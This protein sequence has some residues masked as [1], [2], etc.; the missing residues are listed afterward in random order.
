MSLT[1][2]IADKSSYVHAFFERNFP[3][4]IATRPDSISLMS[5]SI[6]CGESDTSSTTETAIN[7]NFQFGEPL[8]MPENT[9]NYPWAIVGTAF[10][11]RLRYFLEV[12]P[13]EALVA[14]SGAYQ[15]RMH[16]QSDDLPLAFLEL[17]SEFERL[18]PDFGAGLLAPELE[19]YVGSLCIAL[20]QYEACYRAQIR[21]NW[22]VIEIGEKGSLKELLALNPEYVATD[23]VSLASLFYAKHVDFIERTPRIL[24]PNFSASHFLGGAD[25]DLILG[26]RL[27]DIK[28]VQKPKLTREYLW[29]L[30]GYVLAD[31]NDEYEIDEVGFY[32]ARHGQELSWKVQDFFNYL[33]GHDVD[34]SA[35]RREFGELIESKYLEARKIWEFSFGAAKKSPAKKSPAK[36]SPANPVDS[37]LVFKV[38]DRISHK[39]LGLGTVLALSGTGDDVKLHVDF[40]NSGKK[41]LL[42]LYASIKKAP[43]KKAP[44]K[45]APAKKA[46][47]KKAPAKKAQ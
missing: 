47:A 7:T 37:L 23:L 39:E 3:N 32:F 43:A 6:K 24:N 16:F 20:A 12:T 9:E 2:H 45:K 21:E 27:I 1:S 26:R 46:P 19:R 22:S 10:D 38:G 33:A 30:A 14:N 11:Y 42:L 15:V 40:D 31:L 25:A 8:V 35:L 5:L 17:K 13:I 36:K 29:Q 18:A 44:A 4:S 28:T 34:I 41:R